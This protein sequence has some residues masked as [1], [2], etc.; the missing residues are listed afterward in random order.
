MENHL[1]TQGCDLEERISLY[2]DECGK[3]IYVGDR[4]YEICG[5]NFCEECIEKFVKTAEETDFE[6]E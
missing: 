1:V 2:C 5:A 4:Y 6:E 3:E